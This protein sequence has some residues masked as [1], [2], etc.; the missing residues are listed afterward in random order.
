M[1]KTITCFTLA[2]LAFYDS[3]AFARN[4]GILKSK[5]LPEDVYFITKADYEKIKAN[6]GYKL[7]QNWSL[8][9]NF[10]F[11]SYK[12]EAKYSNFEESSKSGTPYSPSV[13]LG[14]G[15]KF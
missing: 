12:D 14:F 7:A 2:F 9:M 11:K 8:D 10:G 13:S 3:S 15:Y 1:K 5:Y 4:T 6:L